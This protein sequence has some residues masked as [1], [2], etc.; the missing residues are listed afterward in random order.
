MTRCVL[1]D[2]DGTLIDS[3]NLYVQAADRTL[4]SIGRN[5]FSVEEVSSL[6]LNTEP[7]LLGYFYPPEEVEHAHRRFLQNYRDLHARYFEGVYPGVTELLTSL[8]RHGIKTGIVSGK[9]RGAWEI[10]RQHV[11]LGDFDT[12]VF[13]DDVSTPKPDC[14]GL[15]EGDVQSGS[16]AVRDHLRR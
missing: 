9:S 15:V 14:E 7:R 2:L 11:C 1:F 13:D 3:W 6:R 5:G 12:L 8:R 16:F 10:T 4:Q